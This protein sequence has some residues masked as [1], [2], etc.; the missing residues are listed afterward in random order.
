MTYF[1]AG[2]D[3]LSM[4]TPVIHNIIILP[5]NNSHSRETIHIAGKQIYETL[6]ETA[7][8]KII[9]VSFFQENATQHWVFIGIYATHTS[10]RQGTP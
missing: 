8:K 7:V 6:H 3:I 5:Y 4:N 1:W 2:I 9:P 10:A